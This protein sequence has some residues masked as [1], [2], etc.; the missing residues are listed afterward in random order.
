MYDL[1]KYTLNNTWEGVIIAILYTLIPFKDPKTDLQLECHPSKVVYKYTHLW[2][3]RSGTLVISCSTEWCILFSLY[4]IH[5][6]SQE[7]MTFFHYWPRQRSRIE[8]TNPLMTKTIKHK[9]YEIISFKHWLSGRAQ[10]WSLT[11][12]REREREIR[13]R[14]WRHLAFCLGNISRL[15]L[16]ERR[17]KQSLALSPSWEDKL[18]VLVGPGGWSLQG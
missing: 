1:P 13:G 16:R 3:F 2:C 4:E 17:H 11:P 15:Y 18:R 5:G 9:I 10:Q 12:K 7:N 14:T 6:E 8:F